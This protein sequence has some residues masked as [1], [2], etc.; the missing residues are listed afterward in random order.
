MYF[1]IY[2]NSS[3]KSK[4]GQLFFIIVFITCLV[5]CKKKG[6]T[7][8][9][10]TN[11][12]LDAKKD[13][14]TCVYEDFDKQAMLTN[15]TNNYIIPAISNYKTKCDA[16][17]NS[18]NSF[19]LNPNLQ[20]L[21]TLRSTW[22]SALLSWQDV[23]FLDFGPAEYIILKSQTN[24][25]PTDTTLI[26]DNINTG[27]WN[28]TNST[29]F[30]QKGF[31]A[32]DYLL[33]KPNF[34]DQQLIDYFILNLNAKDY[35]TDLTQDILDNTT[36]VYNEWNGSY[37]TTFI[38]DYESNAQGSSVSNI[39]NAL[40]LHYE[41]YLRR[42]K[43]GLPLGVFNG[44]SQL[45]MPELVECYYYGQSLP[46]ATQAISSLEKCING[47]NFNTE[48]NGQGFDDYMNFANAVYNNNL[49]SVTINDQISDINSS[50]NALNDPLSSE[51][52]SNK[53]AVSSTYQKMQQL[54]PYL[55]LDMTSSLGVAITYQDNDG[56]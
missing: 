8:P 54:V 4:I 10:A 18:S 11:Y 14:G 26:N 40:C 17:N 23:S 31:Q 12:D 20:N 3:F 21:D 13:N 7:D 27:N 35:L 41:F 43:I 32:L 2:N 48:E 39:V 44:W 28:F 6:C 19:V 15:I 38:N 9:L 37:K 51:I 30:D 36:Y 45:E 1:F 22:V 16:L 53:P 49:L 29:Y 52:T 25:Y 42:G 46:F 34:S 50:L 5:S 56:D 33:N 47:V 24:I 55:K